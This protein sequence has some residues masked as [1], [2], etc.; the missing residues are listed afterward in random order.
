[1]GGG[2]WGVV[3]RSGAA[4]IETPA[5]AAVDTQPPPSTAVTQTTAWSLQ[6]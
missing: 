3:T 6:R 1:M 4:T 2:G 5:T